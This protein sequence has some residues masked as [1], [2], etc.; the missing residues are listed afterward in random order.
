[1]AELAGSEATRRR[2]ARLLAG[3]APWEDG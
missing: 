3:S 2:V 1:V